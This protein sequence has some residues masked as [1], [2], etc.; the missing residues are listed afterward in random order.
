MS[1]TAAL[2]PARL[3]I[4]AAFCP[5]CHWTGQAHPTPETLPRRCPECGYSRHS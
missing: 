5:R 1:V 3:P 2:K 4:W